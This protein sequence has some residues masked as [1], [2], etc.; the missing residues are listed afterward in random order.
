MTLWELEPFLSPSTRGKRHT[1]TV[2][3][4]ALQELVEPEGICFGCGTANPDGLHIRSYWS[5]DGS[6]VVAS[7]APA[8]HFTVWP[9]VVYG[10]Y[11]A[12]LIDCHSNWTAI[13]WHYRAEGREPGSLPAIHCVLARLGVQYR[14]PTPMGIP[15]DLSAW[16]EG[17]AGKQSRIICEVRAEGTLT[18]RGDSLFTRADPALLAR[19]AA[20]IRKS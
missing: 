18:A 16:V 1:R 14:K 3:T 15:L 2:M 9:G 10:G 12:M 6:R 11:L 17:D 13:A 4:I 5:E 19:K 7:V 20:G 8:A